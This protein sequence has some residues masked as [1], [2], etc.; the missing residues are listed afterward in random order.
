M[1]LETKKTPK[2]RNVNREK[3]YQFIIYGVYPVTHSEER[4]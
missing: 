1:I 3:T 4:K 2:F